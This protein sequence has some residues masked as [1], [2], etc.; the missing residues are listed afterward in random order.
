MVKKK[1]DS[2]MLIGPPS[3]GKSSYA[4]NLGG[5]V[6]VSQESCSCSMD[7]LSSHFDKYIQSNE[8][9]RIV[10]EGSFATAQMR[11]KFTAVAKARGIPIK[12]LW[13]NTS[14]DDCAYNVCTTMTREYDTLYNITDF[15][16]T[17]PSRNTIPIGVIERYFERFEMPIPQ[18]G[19]VSIEEV[20]FKREW[21]QRNVK[22]A[23]IVNCNL[24]Y[25]SKGKYPFPLNVDEI[26]ILPDRSE[27]LKQYNRDGY[28]IVALDNLSNLNEAISRNIT[29]EE[30]ISAC[31]DVLRDSLGVDIDFCCCGHL[32]EDRCYCRMPNVGH[33]AFIT[34]RY[35]LLPSKCLLIGDTDIDVEFAKKCSFPHQ[36]S[37]EFFNVKSFR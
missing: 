17:M 22:S 27:V 2:I 3:G 26:E 18:E 11:S 33:G 9:T 28:T 31:Y 1:F 35:H 32:L 30:S 12:C 20:P 10:V 14:I 19:F 7:Q 16:R 4:K 5:K 23:I 36:K 13:L 21:G 8:K 29:T 34:E 25:K 6:T 24:L 15:N 37:S